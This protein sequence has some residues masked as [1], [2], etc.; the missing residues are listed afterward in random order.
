MIGRVGVCDL[1]LGRATAAAD[2]YEAKV[3]TLRQQG[4]VV[5][6]L[7]EEFG[8]WETLKMARPDDV[9]TTAM[10]SGGHQRGG[11]LAPRAPLGEPAPR[12]GRLT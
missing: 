10:G 12:R 8:I 4:A 2:R 5:A 1:D 6:G 7:V 9:S 11:D 3:V